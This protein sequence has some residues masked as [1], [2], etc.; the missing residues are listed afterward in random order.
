VERDDQGAALRCT[1]AECPA[2]KLRTIAHFASR[3]A[4][5]I[6]GLGS[7]VVKLLVEAGFIATPAD[8]YYLNAQDVATLERMGKKSSEN[9]IAAID[10]S[11]ERGLARLLCAFGIRQV[12]QKAA[13]VLA[14]HYKTLD[15]L[16]LAGE[17]EL[18]Q[19][20][21]VGP[22]TAQY[23]REWLDSPQAQHQIQRLREAGVS[24]ESTETIKD[25]RFRGMTFVLTGTLSAFTRDEASAIIES[26]GGKTSSSVSKKTSY[27]LAGEAAGSKLTKAQQ[28]GIPVIS[29]QRFLE[30]TK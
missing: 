16:M 20:P 30:L 15:E 10:G 29:E 2:Q 25:E 13:K 3:E 11:R 14:Q 9:L 24:F 7:A 18:T 26:Y 17:D 28:L 27:V 5:D 4:M 6:E 8:L 21:D 19:I 22:I 12:G 23:L 1:G